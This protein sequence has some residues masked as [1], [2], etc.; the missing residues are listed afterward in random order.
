MQL[1]QAGSTLADET[2]SAPPAPTPPPVDA[3]IVV[4]ITDKGLQAYLNIHPPLNGGSAPT[5]EAL[6]A[7]LSNHHISYN[8]NV[9]MLKKLAENPIYNQDILIATGLAPVDGENGSVTFLIKTEKSTLAPKD[10]GDG[11]VDYHDLDMVENV[12]KGQTLCTITFPTEGTPGISVQGKAM[13]Q[14]KGRVAPSYLGRNTELRP[15]GTAILSKINGQVEL[16]GNKINVDE[17]FYIKENVDNSTGN[18]HV[19]GN[20]V[21]RG[22]V[23]P[24][25]S[26]Q[27][28]GNIEIA[29]AV[30][31]AK[32]SAGGSIKLFSGINNTELNCSGDLR[33][34]FIENSSAFV[35]GDIYAESIIN[36]NVRCGQTIKVGGSIAKIIGGTCIAGQNIEAGTI[37]SLS[38]AKTI[39]ELGT[40]QSVM[41]RQQ[42]LLPQLEQL[43]AQNEK[44]IPLLDIL[45]QL[46]GCNRL[47][48]DKKKI[49]EDVRFSYNHN[50]QV[51][52]SAKIELE[53]IAVSMK[54]KGYGRIICTHT[55]HPGT[56]VVIGDASRNINDTLNNALL[57]YHQ[58]E[59]SIG[60]AH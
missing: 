51:L 17:T 37:G 56:R 25:F 41:Q 26:V 24:G 52:E 39:L 46:E 49:L 18:V 55:M 10:R 2:T 47:D 14:K 22:M 43:E 5:S 35:K 42:E 54:T 31:L 45:M 34:K 8:V 3:K 16:V 15:D 33:C 7:A 60:F 20:L 30:E 59:I 19:A 53:E 21:I 4:S 57:Y 44:L 12:E 29:G 6:N 28:G 40:D 11:T 1:N 9:E 32:I 48:A 27:A 13:P 38:S 50:L 23:L 58:G 36:S